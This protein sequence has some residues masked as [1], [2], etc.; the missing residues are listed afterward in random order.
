MKDR[1]VLKV[2][3]LISLLVEILLIILVFRK[4]GWERMPVQLVRIFIQINLALLILFQKSNVSL[5]IL[6]GYHILASVYAWGFGD[7]RETVIIILAVYHFITG[8]VIY[9]H[10]WLEEK[11][12][13]KLI[14]R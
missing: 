11:I 7:M 3:I 10:E 14:N 1:P 6:S 4:A 5:F 9:F 2:A 8:L 12:K 13:S